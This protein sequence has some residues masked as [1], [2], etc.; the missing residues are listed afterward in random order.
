[1]KAR[2]YCAGHQVSSAFML[3]C[4]YV[5]FEVGLFEK[6]EKRGK[7]G[8]IFI[9]T[10]RREIGMGIGDV[11][12]ERPRRR[13]PEQEQQEREHAFQEKGFELLEALGVVERE[14]GQVMVDIGKLR[15]LTDGAVKYSNENGYNFLTRKGVRDTHT[16]ASIARDL[17]RQYGDLYQ[18]DITSFLFSLFKE[19]KVNSWQ[20]LEAWE[21]AGHVGQP[22]EPKPLFYLPENNEAAFDVE[23][24]KAAQFHLGLWEVGTSNNL[25]R[26]AHSDY[27]PQHPNLPFKE[28]EMA[29]VLYHP[30][31]GNGE[32]N[33]RG[34][35]VV[36]YKDGSR[37]QITQKWIENTSFG[38]F[39]GGQ[40]FGEPGEKLKSM[41]AFLENEGLP[42][43]TKTELLRPTDFEA[44]S[45]GITRLFGET[46]NIGVNGYVIIEGARYYVGKMYGKE[47]HR[48][49]RLSDQVA[50]ICKIVDGQEKIVA[51]F[52][53]KK[54]DELTHAVQTKYVRTA[55]WHPAG[56]SGFYDVRREA[57]TITPYDEKAAPIFTMPGEA[58]Q[59]NMGSEEF[60]ELEKVKKEVARETGVSLESLSPRERRVFLN[61]YAEAGQ[62]K[63]RDYL[64]LIE[65][66]GPAVATAFLASEFNAKAPEE[67]L[68]L[69]EIGESEKFPMADVQK[70]LDDYAGTVRVAEEFYGAVLPKVQSLSPGF[71]T[72]QFFRGMIER[73]SRFLHYCFEA[74]HTGAA[75]YSDIAEEII[76]EQRGLSLNNCRDAI[77]SSAVINLVNAIGDVEARAIFDEVYKETHDAKLRE[78]LELAR[79]FVTPATENAAAVRDLNDFYSHQIRFESYK[80]NEKMER[81]EAELLLDY[82]GED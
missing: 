7:I 31:Y 28:A 70:I 54:R 58:A 22:P 40:Q 5:F 71:K 19:E 10:M 29:C 68:A 44:M 56:K 1:M 8:W 26:R 51:T 43:L 79:S 66:Y 77:V 4:F 55:V 45:G 82:I 41:R 2:E 80:L 33:N 39:R 30:Q 23:K 46:K 34:R 50:A 65:A 6:K 47:P 14:G 67:I 38:F 21:A 73:A 24:I 61:K 64:G 59:A 12:F 49:Y 81:A 42:N 11:A 76:K 63:K 16:V 15:E 57:F 53:L 74:V 75:S 52:T 32:R 35:L 20:E 13:S 72:D 78:S 60:G 27:S 36:N 3:S 69:G 25:V 48:A 37:K 17:F 62:R 18:G 9:I